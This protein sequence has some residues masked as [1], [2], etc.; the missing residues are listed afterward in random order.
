MNSNVNSINEQCGIV[1]Q[2]H[3]QGDP[4]VLCNS[5]TYCSNDPC[6]RGAVSKCSSHSS[7]DKV[8]GKNKVDVDDC[9]AISK[10][11]EEIN[12]INIASYDSLS[13]IIENSKRVCFNEDVEC[14]D[15]LDMYLRTSPQV[16]C[17][18]HSQLRS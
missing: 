9:V 14:G 15:F 12:A 2:G 17:P 8:Q 16:N 13:S 1:V 18:S 5:I 4:N 6:G 11:F 7:R 3:P 10:R